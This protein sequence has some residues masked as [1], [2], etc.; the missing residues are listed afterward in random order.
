EREPGGN[1][2]G[3]RHGLDEANNALLAGR[4]RRGR[5]RAV[6]GV[7]PDGV[8]MDDGN[9]PG[10]YGFGRGRLD[11]MEWPAGLGIFTAR[12]GGYCK[13][14]GGKSER[15][16]PCDKL[17]L[18][19]YPFQFWKEARMILQLTGILI[20]ATSPAKVR[21]ADK[22]GNCVPNEG[23]LCTAIWRLCC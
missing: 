2:I 11:L 13:K 5:R 20:S 16:G 23:K 12:F 18:H 4:R 9:F 3:R 1:A 21:L 14:S 6:G 19:D 8:V 17:V 10:S 22:L 15:K 7:M